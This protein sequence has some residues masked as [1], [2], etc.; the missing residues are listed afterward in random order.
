MIDGSTVAANLGVN[1]S[2]TIAAMAERATSL[3][4]N[5][6]EDDPR[7]SPGETYRPCAPVAPR[8]PVVPSQAPG[9]LRLIPIH[10]VSSTPT[11]TTIPTG[12]SCGRDRPASVARARRER[13]DGD[14]VRR[15]NLDVAP[16]PRRGRGGGG[17]PDRSSPTR[18][19]LHVGTLLGN[20]PEMLRAMA[21]AGLGGYI[22][23]RDQH[24]AP[25]RRRCSPTC[26]LRVP[27][28]VD[29]RR[30]PA[31]ARRPGPGRRAGPRRLYAR[32]GRHRR[33]RRAARPAS[34]GRRR[35]TPS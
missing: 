16:A 26:A 25:R 6:G 11:S 33:R 12:D 9:A 20:T 7:P 21:A 31:T 24:H 14:P 15:P 28:P 13:Q 19:P 17:R 18:T 1:P 10:P 2:L 5:R 8:A 27:D 4:P 30:A 23:V 3:W 32:V 29:R 34:R 35:W 22:A